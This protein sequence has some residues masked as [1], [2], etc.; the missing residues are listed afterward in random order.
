MRLRRSDFIDARYAFSFVLANFGI[1]IAAR[2]PMITTTI[3]SSIS[4]KPLRLTTLPPVEEKGR[5]APPSPDRNGPPQKKRAAVRPAAR[6]LSTG[7]VALDALRLAF[8]VGRGDRRRTH[9]NAAGLGRGRVA[10]RRG[11]DR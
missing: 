3:S 1:A 11:P 5:C 9:V 4:V 10:D 8:L 2:M 7:A 6:S